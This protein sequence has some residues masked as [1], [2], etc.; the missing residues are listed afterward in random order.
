[1]RGRYRPAGGCDLASAAAVLSDGDV[2]MAD[3]VDV[4]SQPDRVFTE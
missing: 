1:M 3:A 4:L 2:E